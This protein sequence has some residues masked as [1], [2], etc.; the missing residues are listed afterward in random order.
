MFIH[1]KTSS[2]EEGLMEFTR[3]PLGTGGDRGRSSQCLCWV[4]TSTFLKRLSKAFIQRSVMPHQ[5]LSK[6]HLLFKFPEKLK[7]S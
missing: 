5:R 7:N 1:V 3:A 4:Y 2:S 6:H